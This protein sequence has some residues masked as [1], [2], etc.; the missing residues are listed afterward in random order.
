MELQTTYKETEVGIIPSDWDVKKIAEV[1]DV[2]GGKRLPKGYSLT[3]HPTPHPYVRVADMYQGG[4]STEDIR[5]VPEDAF[6]LIQNYRI[7]SSDVFISVAGT[8]GLV[9]KVP[10]EL[11]GANLTENADR[12]TN[13]D[14]DQD[15]L[16]AQLRSD[17]VQQQVDSVR[18]VGA[19]PKLALSRIREFLIPLP[20]RPEQRAIAEALSDVDALIERLDA[21]IAKKRA[22]KTATMQRL[23]T[24]QQRLPGF[25]APWATKRLGD[26]GRCIRGVSYDGDADLYPYDTE[27]TKRLFRSNNVQDGDLVVSDLQ[28]VNEARVSTDQIMRP[29]DILICTANGS[30]DLVG[31]AARFNLD[32]GHE[33][34]F[35]AFMGCFRPDRSAADPSFVSR[36]FQSGRYRKQ[37]SEIL[38]GTSINNLKPSDIE[39]L[40]FSFPGREEQKAIATI[41]SDMGAE[42]E[43]LRARRDKTQAIKQGMMQELLTGRTRLV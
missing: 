38:A 43:A 19:Q 10:S 28:F 14:C 35:G 9:G 7:S 23:L 41:L 34:T 2:R 26:V 5:Y 24:G 27:N 33:Y 6:P 40:S 31:K 12:I 32:G 1:G 15:F 18:T 42:I 22:I 11:D 37:L 36:L 3:Q 17:R 21:L 30:R 4:V 29:D 39:A 8:L 20:P 13:L 16:I 25:S